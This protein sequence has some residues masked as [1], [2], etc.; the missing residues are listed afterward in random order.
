V[1]PQIF[2]KTK[3]G[4]GSKKIENHC[5]GYDLENSEQKVY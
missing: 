3:V 5:L 1:E 2:S 4:P